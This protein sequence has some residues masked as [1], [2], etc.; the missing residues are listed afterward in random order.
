MEDS[1][2][3][4]RHQEGERST[5]DS[6]EADHPQVRYEEGKSEGTSF[7]QQ[8]RR[9]SL[10]SLQIP[11]R[12][13][14]SSLHD[15]TKSEVTS[16]QSPCS[17]RAVLPPR[18]SSAMFKSPMR[19]F[20][21]QRS[22]RTRNLSENGETTVLII[23]D[24]PVSDVPVDKPSTSSLFSLNKAFFTTS[25][26][27]TSSLPVTPIAMLGSTSIQER[28]LNGGSEKPLEAKHHIRRSLSVPVSVKLKT[29]KRLESGGSR[30]RMVLA[31]PHP[32]AA[33]VLAK[34]EDERQIDSED[35]GEDIP[36]EDAV[37]RICMIE[38]GEGGD[39]L[40]LECSCKG[41]LALAHQECAVKWFS[42]KGNHTCDVCGHA[43]RNLPVKLLKI[44]NPQTSFR[45]TIS[46]SP[47]GEMT[48]YRV[49]QEIP[50]LILVSM[51]AYFCFLEQLLVSD[52][53]AFALAISL[54]FSCLLGL[55]SSM[56]ASTMVSRSYI[57]AYSCFQFAIV[58]LFAH[59]FYAILNVR[60]VLSILLSSFLGFGTSISINYLILEYF[61]W[62]RSRQLQSSIQ[63]INRATEQ[64]QQ[65]HH[66]QSM[67]GSIV[68]ATEQAAV[69]HNR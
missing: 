64:Q 51:L 61:R 53:G 22:L 6:A 20:F 52:F 15:F 39:T 43:V 59:V 21:P 13:L 29:L 60:A 2:S 63:R 32:P 4:A 36:E 18:P 44:H 67:E 9:P 42:I 8:S 50:V 41:D 30:F 26:K 12:S 56:I 62:R 65:E 54:P 58:I 48:D 69:S 34:G 3:A 57:W 37:C 1:A 28:D 38:L 19:H 33:D 47:H 66:Q 11:E 68:E 49:W 24:T 55:L 5:F 23:P 35:G 46:I 14:E 17:S 10:S 7:S 16:V 27:A 25:S 40:K 45:Q 31:N